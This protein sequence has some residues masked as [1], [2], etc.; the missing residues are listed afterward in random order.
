MIEYIYVKLRANLFYS[1]SSISFAADSLTRWNIA[2]HDVW[3]KEKKNIIWSSS[4][5]QHPSS[6]T[7][8]EFIERTRERSSQNRNFS[9][10]AVFKSLYLFAR[11]LLALNIKHFHKKRRKPREKVNLQKSLI[12]S[13]VNMCAP[14]SLVKKEKNTSSRVAGLGIYVCERAEQSEKQVIEVTSKSNRVAA[15]AAWAWSPP[16]TP[17]KLKNVYGCSSRSRAP[18]QKK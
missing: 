1:C 6:F 5:R 12:F 15:A 16:H 8:E 9:F 13:V 11:I 14:W 10:F 18:S 3:L 7:W 2:H 17:P 4:A